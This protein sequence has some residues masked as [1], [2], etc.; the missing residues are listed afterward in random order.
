MNGDF[1]LV[2]WA[3][4]IG[5]LS[6]ISL[7]LG[8]VVGL[9][10]QPRAS[11]A[12]VLAGFGAG[13]LIAAL[14]VEL[15]APTVEAIGEHPGAVAEFWALTVGAVAGGVVF[16]L[17]DN[18]LAA[19]GG[20]LRKVAT[21][22][23]HYSK[24]KHTRDA[25]WLKDLCAIPL[26][27]A[28]PADQVELLIRDVRAE[29]FAQGDALFVE[30]EPASRLYFIRTGEVELQRGASSIGRLG[31]GGILGELALVAELPRQLT[32][33]ALGPTEALVLERADF[34]R[35]RSTCPEFD[36]G[37]R[38]LAGQQ[39][40]EIRE[41]DAETS[42]EEENWARAAIAALREGAAVPSPAEVRK[43]AD[44]HGG[45]GLAVWLGML[46]DG[47]P[48]SIVLGAGFLG[49]V[50]ARVAAGET[51]AFVD[52]VPF[53]LVAGLFL[54]NFPE[55]L[56]SSLAL[57]A[58]GWRA[59]SIVGLWAV[60]LVVTAVGAGVGYAIGE[61]LPHVV[62]AAIEGVAAGA[63]L[64]AIG[65]TMIPEA[66]H[67]SGSGSRVGLATLFGFLSAVCFK[68]LE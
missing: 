28:L 48:E 22:I 7:P 66:V 39:L 38:E 56:S 36:T 5:A 34:D 64:T 27:R 60:L 29:S 57:R 6:A 8:S 31:T 20:F 67:L 53:T 9:V 25:Q 2:G 3:I 61:S 17:L 12:A 62:L 35:W 52:V 37:V 33:R 47:I 18:M 23:T 16:V 10:L 4:A 63:M 65:S 1:G 44:E 49:L 13:A 30:G 32:A 26:L 41:R 58:Q 54:A 24:R 21:T 55:A 59:E 45:A 43:M 42:A 50:S 14:A 46:I 40:E 11:I 19:R 68:L 15:V 51:V